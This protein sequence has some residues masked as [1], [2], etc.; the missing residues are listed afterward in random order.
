MSR[1]Q[2]C[3]LRQKI[4]LFFKTSQVLFILLKIALRLCEGRQL[5]HIVLPVILFMNILWEP[6]EL[7]IEIRDSSNDQLIINQEGLTYCPC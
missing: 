7:L 1:D 2:T 6:E 3:A 4:L 5:L